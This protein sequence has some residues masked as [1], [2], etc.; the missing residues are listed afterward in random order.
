[1]VDLYTNWFE[2]KEWSSIPDDLK[3]GI[4]EIAS[5]VVKRKTGS[6]DNPEIVDVEYIRVKMHDKL[7]ALWLI[8]RILGFDKPIKTE[9]D[10][11][12]RDNGFLIPEVVLS[13]LDTQDLKTLHKIIEKAVT[14]FNQKLGRA[15]TL[16]KVELNEIYS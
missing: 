11:P 8:C 5:S 2:L 6:S 7:R 3:A 1:V 12:S 13:Q 16:T 9:I 10:F 14:T 4:C 15:R